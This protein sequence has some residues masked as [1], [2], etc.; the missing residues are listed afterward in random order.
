MESI[1]WKLVAIVAAI[2]GLLAAFSASLPDNIPTTVP[3][4]CVAVPL[5]AGGQL[6]AGYCP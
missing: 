4:A 1:A 3:P 6:Q 2:A 5:V